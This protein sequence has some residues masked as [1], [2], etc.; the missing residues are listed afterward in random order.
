MERPKTLYLH[1]GPNVKDYSSINILRHPKNKNRRGWGDTEIEIRIPGTDEVIWRGHNKVILPGAGFLA[2]AMFDIPNYEEITPSYNT[3]LGLENTVYET[4]DSLHKTFLFCVGTDGC[5]REMSQ[6]F[7]V[8]Y[9][10][11]CAPENLVPFRYELYSED[12]DITLREVYFGRKEIGD[13]IAYYFK[14]FESEPVFY[15]QYVD[16]TP[17]DSNVYTSNKTEEI[18]SYV[19]LRLAVT[20]EDCRDY[21][22][23]TTG[24]NDA[25]INTISLCTAWRK[26]FEEN[27]QNIIYMQDVRPITKLNYSSEPLIDLSKG[28]DIIY[29]VYF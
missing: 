13:R 16:G 2:R 11:W 10:K 27:G 22:I 5:G 15:Q 21:F 26:T 23:Q 17:I 14:A 29:H 19:E 3:A 1:D 8:D 18:E 28:L 12:L 6:V 25:R 9:G 4:P 20:K 24:I 7:D